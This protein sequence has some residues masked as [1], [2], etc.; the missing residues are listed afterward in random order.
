M[1]KRVLLKDDDDSDGHI[2][3]EEDEESENLSF[4]E[5]DTDIDEE[6]ADV[7]T[8]NVVFDTKEML[9]RRHEAE[10]D[11]CLNGFEYHSLGTCRHFVT[12]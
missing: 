4:E 3:S 9:S 8:A 11:M 5:D 7:F 10:D 6:E 2:E 1:F 12:G